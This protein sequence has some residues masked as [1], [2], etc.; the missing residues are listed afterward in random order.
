MF[1]YLGAFL[2][3]IAELLV[4]HLMK[5]RYLDRLMK[6]EEQRAMSEEYK[7]CNVRQKHHFVKP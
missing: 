5:F 1:Q 2:T 3:H 4:V 7:D 6:Q